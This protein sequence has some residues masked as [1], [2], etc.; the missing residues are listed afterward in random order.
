MGLAFVEKMAAVM[1]LIPLLG[2]LLVSRLGEAVRKPSMAAWID[3]LVTTGAM[4]A[5]LA[6]AFQ[7]IQLLQ[8]QLPPPRDINLFIHRPAS[9]WP[10]TILAIPLVVWFIRRGLGRLFRGSQVWG[11]ERPALVA[12]AAEEEPDQPGQHEDDAP[13]REGG[14]R[15]GSITAAVP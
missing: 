1:V 7:Q 5:P 6:L 15:T 2:W 4:L 11:V 12:A 3:G 9:D 13:D 8:R 10:G 14:H